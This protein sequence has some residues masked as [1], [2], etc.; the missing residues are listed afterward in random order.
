M[1]RVSQGPNDIDHSEV[2]ELEI[3]ETTKEEVIAMFGS[4]LAVTVNAK[5]IEVYTFVWGNSALQM[6]QVPPIF[7]IYVNSVS[8]AKFKVLTVTFSGDT[9]IDWSFTVRATG[10]GTQAG[11][12]QGGTLGE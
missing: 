1:T 4:P 7:V 11:N 12:V 2:Q 8:S 5:G 10:G 9:V 3:G 6:W